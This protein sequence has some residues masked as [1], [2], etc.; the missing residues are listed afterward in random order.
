MKKD[1]YKS[2]K[3]WRRNTKAKIVEGFGGICACCGLIDHP[4]AYDFHHIDPSKKDFQ[5]AGL[6]ISW[7]KLVEEAKKC[8]LLCSICHRKCHFGLIV[9]P[10]DYRQFDESLIHDRG[11]LGRDTCP[12]CDKLKSIKK[13]ICSKCV[14]AAKNRAFKVDWN[15][16]D[17]KTL[18]TQI[19]NFEA[20]GRMIGC[21]GA[22]VKKHMR[23]VGLL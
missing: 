22:A 8:V 19:E 5:I 17:V 3:D 18:Y 12:L 2:V 23:K 16:Y 21:T 11:I 10:D 20:I 7:E 13:K 4:I 14:I 9:I 15:K 1:S 6:S